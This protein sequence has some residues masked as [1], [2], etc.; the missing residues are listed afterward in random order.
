MIAHDI[1]TKY[2]QAKELYTEGKLSERQW[3]IFCEEVLHV[4][5]TEHKDVFERLNDR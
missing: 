3:M 5:M 4:L 1:Y 2:T